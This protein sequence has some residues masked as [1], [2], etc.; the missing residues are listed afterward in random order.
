MTLEEGVHVQSLYHSNPSHETLE[1]QISIQ[2]VNL[3]II[4]ILEQPLELLHWV[5]RRQTHL[6]SMDSSLEFKQRLQAR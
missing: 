5:D 4:N 2:C 3:T 1:E 6:D